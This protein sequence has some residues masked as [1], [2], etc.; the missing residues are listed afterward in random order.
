MTWIIEHYLSCSEEETIVDILRLIPMYEDIDGNVL[1]CPMTG[2]V[3]YAE[4]SE[5]RAKAVW[6]EN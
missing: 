3:E 6:E 2:E 1:D 5:C 4:C